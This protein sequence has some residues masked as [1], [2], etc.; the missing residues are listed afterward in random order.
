MS[1]LSLPSSHWGR[2]GP[3]KTERKLRG[4]SEGLR[5][6]TGAEDAETDGDEETGEGWNQ[7]GVKEV[8]KG[9]VGRE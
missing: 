8:V 7:V 3:D 2:K 6:K 9:R 1:S 5:F 4:E